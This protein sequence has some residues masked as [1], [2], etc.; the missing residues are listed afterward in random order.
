MLDYLSSSLSWGIITGHTRRRTSYGLKTPR[1][2]NMSTTP[3]TFNFDSPVTPDG[4]MTDVYGACEVTQDD[5]LNDDF[6]PPPSENTATDAEDD[7]DDSANVP[8]LST[9]TNHESNTQQKRTRRTP[10][11][12]E[13]M[14][15]DKHTHLRGRGDMSHPDRTFHLRCH[16]TVTADRKL[17]KDQLRIGHIHKIHSDGMSG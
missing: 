3:E 5:T 1:N 4:N 17:H 13:R 12:A 2:A 9:P 15:F 8:A 14:W 6:E 11:E 7:C 10:L 16:P